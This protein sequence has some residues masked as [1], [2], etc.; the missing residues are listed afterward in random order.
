VTQLIEWLSEE[1]L[2]FEFVFVDDA[3]RQLE[4]ERELI[5]TVFRDQILNGTVVL[6]ACPAK[7]LA[8]RAEDRA[9]TS[10]CHLITVSQH[11]PGFELENAF[12][13]RLIVD[14]PQPRLGIDEDPAESI[15]ADSQI[16]F[17][18]ELAS[19]LSQQLA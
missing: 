16:A 11:D 13:T 9:R 4:N 10:L 14:S 3:G 18:S 2:V 7:D 1:S 5:A 8:P 15:E 17:W 12:L 19:V 6:T